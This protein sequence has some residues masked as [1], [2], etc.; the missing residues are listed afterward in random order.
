MK[1]TIV[2][3]SIFP[4]TDAVRAFASMEDYELIVVGDRKTPADWQCDGVQF[5]DVTAQEA[6]AQKFCALVPF[7]NYARKMLGYVAALRARPPAIVDSDDD[8]LPYE[9]WGF[10]PFDG[11]Y[12]RIKGGQGFVNI[13]AGYTEH[14][15]WPRGLPLSHVQPARAIARAPAADCKIGV[16]NGLADLEP[17]VD[18]IYRLTA[19]H[20][21]QFRFEKNPPLVLENGSYTPFNSQNT[22]F[23]PACFP[24]LYLPISVSFRFTDILRG[25]VAQCIMQH[26]GLQVGFTQASVY[27]LRNPHDLMD[28]LRLEV[29]MYLRVEEAVEVVAA[30]LKARRMEDNL[31]EA[32]RALARV[33]IVGKPELPCLDAWLDLVNAAASAPR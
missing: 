18:A 23:A 14:K 5:L 24:L 11:R 10:P 9:G 26:H 4:P 16:W 15:I 20:P 22:I 3:T 7:N 6:L 33:G 31:L 21:D 17:D 13:F 1:P 19:D 25:Y 28:D 29:E 30:A 32:Y 27:Q 12:A 2:I 8:N